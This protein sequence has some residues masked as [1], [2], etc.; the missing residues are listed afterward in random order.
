MSRGIGL[1]LVLLTFLI[2][3][4]VGAFAWKPE[5]FGLDA[6]RKPASTSG[7]V[8]GGAAAGNVGDTAAAR[9]EGYWT[10]AMHPQVHKAEPGRCPI[11]GMDLYYRKAEEPG[12]ISVDDKM[13]ALLGIV[14]V[15]V[16]RDTSGGEIRA[17]ARV[18]ENERKIAHVHTRVQGWIEELMIDYAGQ[19][20]VKG[21]P[22]LTIYSPE[23]FA[24]E[25]EYVI[26]M[27]ASE[28]LATSSDPDARK[29]AESLLHAAEQRLDLYSVPADELARLR[30]TRKASRAITLHAPASGYVR[31]MTVRRGM[32]VMP[33]QTLFSIADLSSVWILADVYE[34]EMR[35]VSEGMPVTIRINQLPGQDFSGQVDYIFPFLN[36]EARTNQVRITLLNAG[37]ALRPGMYGTIILSRKS[38]NELV[39]PIDAVI[40]TGTRD[41]VYVESEPGKFTAREVEIGEQIGG[42][43]VVKS[44][45]R[46]GE[47]VVE[48]ANYF[49]DSEASIRNAGAGNTPTP[50]P[51]AHPAG[52]SSSADTQVLPSPVAPPASQ[53][54]PRTGHSH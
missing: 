31:E 28:R 47:Q 32:E 24:S 42:R 54:A 10:C 9:E 20:V 29:R 2:L 33:S 8:H 41:I 18:A 3:L 36:A 4:L 25:E 49:L 43:Y 19:K 6:G 14:T 46:E 48:T 45:L 44:G 40:R 5:W 34:N 26:A 39:V 13:R 1:I 30:M 21:E 52:H 22:L 15:P 51:S 53:P 17:V 16:T 23:L 11:C 27:D 37:T 7:H 12:V 38:G 50:A 35:G